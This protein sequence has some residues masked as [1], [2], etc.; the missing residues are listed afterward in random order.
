MTF[1]WYARL[2]LWLARKGGWTVPAPEIVVQHVVEQDP[3]VVAERDELLEHL[4][5]LTSLLGAKDAEI[6]TSQ[7]AIRQLG[8]E[9][10]TIRT[11]AVQTW[12]ASL[13]GD[14][15]ERVKTLVSEWSGL[16]GSGEAK[17]HQVY[18]RL[19]KEFPNVLKRDLGLAIEMAL[20][21]LKEG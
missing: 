20:Q 11:S 19:I 18:A 7:D 3:K 10:R 21:P 6:K 16:S 9:L 4:R 14:T 15:F 1:P 12:S 5:V 2:G 17:R 13:S 8:T